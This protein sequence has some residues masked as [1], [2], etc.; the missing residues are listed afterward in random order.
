MRHLRD[1]RSGLPVN[2]KALAENDKLSLL[3]VC[4]AEGRLYWQVLWRGDTLRW[5]SERLSTAWLS[6]HLTL[7][8]GVRT[9]YQGRPSYKIIEVLL[10]VAPRPQTPEDTLWRFNHPW[11]DTFLLSWIQTVRLP[12]GRITSMGFQLKYLQTG[13]LQYEGVSIYIHRHEGLPFD[14][15]AHTV[16][17]SRLN[18]IYR[19]RLQTLLRQLP[20]YAYIVRIQDYYPVSLKEAQ[21]WMKYL[22][23]RKRDF[24]LPAAITSGSTETFILL[25]E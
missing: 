9:W 19:Q 1:V 11:L 24:P 20:A 6:R 2:V 12:P 13:K 10:P 25:S 17:L 23:Q 22:L 15:K 16:P 8:R 18:R 21:E 7:L 3:S 5:V 4:K 14:E